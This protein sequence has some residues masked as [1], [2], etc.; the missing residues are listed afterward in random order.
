[1]ITKF[2]TEF[3]VQG[4][5]PEKCFSLPIQISAG[6]QFVFYKGAPEK[7]FIYLIVNKLLSLSLSL[8]LS[9][10]SL[11]YANVLK[12]TH[13]RGKIDPTQVQKRPTITDIPDDTLVIIVVSI[14]SSLKYLELLYEKFLS[15]LRYATDAL[16][17]NTSS[18]LYKSITIY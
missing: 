3:V 9:L 1:M 6:M 8:S 18:Y 15:F 13:C 5:S 11:R 2:L 16:H 17:Q 14:S 10:N 12:E 4:H 7:C